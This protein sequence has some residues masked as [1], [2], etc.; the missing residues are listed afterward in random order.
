MP[1]TG[2][3]SHVSLEDGNIPAFLDNNLV[4]IQVIVELCGMVLLLSCVN[5]VELCWQTRSQD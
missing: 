2:L 1:K 4:L 3:G 5:Y